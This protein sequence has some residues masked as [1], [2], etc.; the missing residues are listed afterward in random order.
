MMLENY[1]SK[2]SVI[3]CFLSLLSGAVLA[4]DLPKGLLS[5]GIA[6][7]KVLPAVTTAATTAGKTNE[8]DSVVQSIDSQLIDRLHGT[9]K[10]T[11]VSRSDLDE[12]L[13][14]QKLTASGNVDEN[15][16]DAAQ[17]F[18]LAGC[19]YVVV[20]TVDQFQDFTATANFANLGTAAH[21]RIVQ[22]SAVAKLW[23]TTTGK[24]RESTNFQCD[25]KQIEKDPY[26]QQSHGDLTDRLFQAMARSMSQLISDRV[27][28]VL[29]PA[30]ILARTDTTVTVNRGDGTTI[31]IGDMWNVFAVGKEMIDPDT[32]V[33]LGQ[34]EIKVGVVRITEVDPLFSKGEVV[35]DHGVDQGQIL[36]RQQAPNGVATPAAP[37]PQ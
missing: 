20:V 37:A 22:F 10:F 13:K 26:Y 32:G 3:A 17:A 5:V 34:E 11:V 8:L 18:K 25:N 35:E 24:L 9:R 12:V 2:G 30:K 16:V 27:C 15:D 1:F 36:R 6:N 19:K 28:D 4:Q 14:E 33:S 21:K 23:D 7:V 29:R 31:A